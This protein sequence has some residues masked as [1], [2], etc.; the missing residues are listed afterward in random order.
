M[1]GIGV[2]AAMAIVLLGLLLRNNGKDASGR[3]AWWISKCAQH[4]PL[5]DCERDHD[6]IF[7][8]P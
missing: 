1:I 4:R 2:L 3:D 6:R 8:E 7:I 5:V